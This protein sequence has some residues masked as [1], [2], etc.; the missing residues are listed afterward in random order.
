MKYPYKL[1]TPVDTRI[2][3]KKHPNLDRILAKGYTFK[4]EFEIYGV[5]MGEVYHK[6]HKNG[7]V[8]LL[9]DP[10]VD[11]IFLIKRYKFDEKLAYRAH[12]NLYKSIPDYIWW[13]PAKKI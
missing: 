7:K 10:E 5:A 11:K 6:S 1:D 4:E 9:Y 8:L 3:P 12:Y 13:V 2:L